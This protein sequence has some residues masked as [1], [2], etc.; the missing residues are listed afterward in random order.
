MASSGGDVGWK[1]PI[2][3]SKF[4]KIYSIQYDSKY[5]ASMDFDCEETIYFDFANLFFR[6][7]LES[8][9]D[10]WNPPNCY[11]LDGEPGL[12]TF[13]GCFHFL[14]YAFYDTLI[15]DIEMIA[16]LEKYGEILPIPCSDNDRTVYQYH[17][18][19]CLGKR[20]ELILDDEAAKYP[21]SN[22]DKIVFRKDQ[23]PDRGLF[24]LRPD[25]TFLYT[26]E[27]EELGI[28]HNFKMLYEARG[29]TGLDFVEAKLI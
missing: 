28:E 1:F 24:W 16:L 14:S 7:E 26:V 23:M 15:S 18:M 27:N 29:Y 21:S 12:A 8:Y 20:R 9:L 17:C 11:H 19:N 22:R 13:T 5:K 4:M 25:Q 6:K 2:T 3:I 10:K